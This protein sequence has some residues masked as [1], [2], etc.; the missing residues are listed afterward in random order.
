M[1]SYTVFVHYSTVK[2]VIGLGL[3]L[4]EARNL[5]ARFTQQYFGVKSNTFTFSIR[6]E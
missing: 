1:K 5:I 2:Q 3:S 4:E 6:E